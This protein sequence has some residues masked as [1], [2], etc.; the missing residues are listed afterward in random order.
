[1]LEDVL[2]ESNDNGKVRQR[3]NRI[4]Q[5]SSKNATIP[6]FVEPQYTAAKVPVNLHDR[7]L[8]VIVKLLSLELEQGNDDLTTSYYTDVSYYSG[9]SWHVEGTP[10]EG[11]VASACCYLES[12]NVDEYGL[13]F[14]DGSEGSHGDE[15]GICKTAPGRILAWPNTLH[16]RVRAVWLKDGSPSGHRTICCFNLVDPTLRVRSTATVPPQQHAWLASEIDLCLESCV[17]EAAVRNHVVKIHQQVQEGCITYEE[18]CD[19]RKR[20]SK[21]RSQAEYA[22]RETFYMLDD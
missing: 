12:E 21:E 13:Q 19:R 1:L 16:H 7:P 15:L 20:L 11:I 3:T 9:G 17:M 14:R 6:D 22:I 4:P 10:E 18:A 8:Q 5:S 2:A